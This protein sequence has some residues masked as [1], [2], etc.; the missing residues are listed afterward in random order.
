[1]KVKL[2]AQIFSDTVANTIEICS[3][4]LNIDSCQNS[5]ATVEFIR[6][7][8]RFDEFEKY[9]RACFYEIVV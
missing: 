3:N 4:E 9:E 6:K 7:I 8:N 2:V 1:M 5:E